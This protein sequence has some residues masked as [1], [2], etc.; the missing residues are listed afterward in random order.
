[1]NCG[2]NVLF[3]SSAY[4]GGSQAV[5]LNDENGTVT[6]KQL[7]Y[8]R[9]LRVHHGDAVCVDDHIYGASGDFGGN[10]FVCLGLKTGEPGWRERMPR[11]NCVYADGKL[12]I[13]DEDGNLM[14]VK[15]TPEKYDCLAK[16]ELLKKVAWTVPT[17]VDTTLYVR[18]R[19]TIMALDLGKKG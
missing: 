10:L 11:A 3:C 5:Q 15:A 17:L 13:L 2:N 7:W 19:D 12:L 9:K 8:T 16:C 4:S 18:D 14:L 6:P 1:V